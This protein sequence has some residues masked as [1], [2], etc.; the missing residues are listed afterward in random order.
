MAIAVLGLLT[1]T[2]SNAAQAA[3]SLQSFSLTDTFTNF[4]AASPSS[5]TYDS[6]SP[7]LTVQAFE[8]NLGT[9]T[10]TTVV[11]ATTATFT[12]PQA[13]RVRLALRDSQRVEIRISTPSATA[14]GMAAAVAAVVT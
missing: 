13:L 11:W 4:P 14:A 5:A 10:S 9:L 12:A 6:T 3:M 2:Q 1:V 8:A 7:R